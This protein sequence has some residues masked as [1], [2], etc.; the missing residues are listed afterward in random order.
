MKSHLIELVEMERD[1]AYV[2]HGSGRS[3][4]QLEPRQAYTVVNGQS[5]KDGEPA[6]FASELVDYAIFMALID[7]NWISGCRASCSFENGRLVYG[8]NQLTIDQFAKPIIGFVHVLEKNKFAPRCGI[9]WMCTSI[10][11][12]SGVLEVTVDDFQKTI[13]ILPDC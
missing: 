8:A 3:H 5:I 13:R 2:F 7:V 6:I 11:K 1:G 12:P 9:E 10:V 4:D